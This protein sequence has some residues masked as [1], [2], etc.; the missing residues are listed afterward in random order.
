[1][2]R[3][4]VYLLSGYRAAVAFISMLGHGTI[5]RRKEW[6]SGFLPTKYQMLFM[7]SLAVI[8]LV[9]SMIVAVCVPEQVCS[10][11]AAEDTWQGTKVLY[12]PVH[13]QVQKHG[14]FQSLAS[15]EPANKPYVK[16]ILQVN[17]NLFPQTTRR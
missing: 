17:R 4:P 10:C 16:A 13:H 5:P 1:M 14:H 6:Q 2:L 15:S 3:F 9:L 7:L 12:T 11:L 8:S